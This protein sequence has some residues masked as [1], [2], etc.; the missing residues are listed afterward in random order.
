MRPYRLLLA[1]L[2]LA[3]GLA[4]PSASAAQEQPGA[5]TRPHRAARDTVSASAYEGWKQYSLHCARCHG[6]DG[7]GTS[8]GPDL[9]AALRPNGTVPNQGAFVAVIVA[10]RPGKGMPSGTTLGLAADH[11]AGMY[12]YLSGRSIGRLVGGRPARRDR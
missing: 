5:T 12:E 7:L 8:F 10:G 2:V 11:H 4:G 9:V 3:F 6:E 1:G